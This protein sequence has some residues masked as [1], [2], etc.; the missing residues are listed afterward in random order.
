MAIWLIVTAWFE[1]RWHDVA[2]PGTGYG[3][4]AKF[5]YRDALVVAVCS[6]AILAALFMRIAPEH[7]HAKPNPDCA[8][9]MSFVRRF[10]RVMKKYDDYI[11][12][13]IFGAGIVLFVGLIS[14]YRW[15][16]ARNRGYE[17]G[18]FGEFN[19]ISNALATVP[20]VTI[21][22]SWHNLDVTLEEFGFGI[23]ITG[24]TARLY[25]GERD[26]LRELSGGAAVAAL[27]T[28]IAQELAITNR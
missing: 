10:S 9:L 23:T 11:L 6:S 28:R 16:A 26:G 3:L 20:G 24:R 2:N 27:Q 19:S 21:T 7:R 5:V 25:F 15:D 1:W 17:W 8:I 12:P 18:Y 4:G 14:F 13:G 22:Q